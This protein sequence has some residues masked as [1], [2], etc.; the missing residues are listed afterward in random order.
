MVGVGVVGLVKGLFR[1]NTW[2]CRTFTLGT[3]TR[4]RV[5]K[6]TGC[7]LTP[8]NLMRFKWCFPKERRQTFTVACHALLDTFSLLTSVSANLKII[9]LELDSLLNLQQHFTLLFIHSSSNPELFLCRPVRQINPEAREHVCAP[10]G[11]F[12]TNP[13]HTYCHLLLY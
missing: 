5:H 3:C 10:A 12:T 1:N 6:S 7:P 2:A 4:S 11:T 13:L 9:T 8:V